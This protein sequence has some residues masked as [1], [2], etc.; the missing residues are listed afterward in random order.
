MFGGL[1]RS[2]LRSAGR[3]VVVL[4]NIEQG[5]ES[6]PPAE[7]VSVRYVARGCE[8]YR[9]GARGYRLPAG[10]VLIAPHDQGAD[11]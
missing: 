9:I 4:S 6:S 1:D 3:D 10:Q 5:V 8:N 7:G 2:E 11:C